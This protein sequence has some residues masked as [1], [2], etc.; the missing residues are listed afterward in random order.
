MATCEDF[1]CCGHEQ[2]RCP[3]HDENGNEIHLCLDCG[4]ELPIHNH[5]SICR[6]CQYIFDRR[7]E[8]GQFDGMDE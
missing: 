7:V 5:S 2:G 3:S 8:D 6:Q 1:P 4:R